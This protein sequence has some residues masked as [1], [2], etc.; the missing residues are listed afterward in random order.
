M[1]EQKERAGES[2]VSLRLYN[3]GDSENTAR[4]QN[5]C[6]WLR[7]DNKM[8]SSCKQEVCII[9]IRTLRW[10]EESSGLRIKMTYVKKS[11]YLECF[12]FLNLEQGLLVPFSLGYYKDEMK[13][14]KK[15]KTK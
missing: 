2:D 4:S 9:I 15:F 12:Q 6:Q 14:I 7:W 8:S 5:S 1:R 13:E 11:L 10:R 3:P